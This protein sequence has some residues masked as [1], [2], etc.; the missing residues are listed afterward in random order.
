[1]SMDEQSNTATGRLYTSAFAKDGGIQ[2][3]SLV[4][5]PGAIC[6]T[7]GEKTPTKGALEMRKW[8]A[9]KKG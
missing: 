5:E 9:K 1:M 7:C 6:P 8:R 4:P 2:Y 3:V